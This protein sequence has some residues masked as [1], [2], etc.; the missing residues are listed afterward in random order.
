[1]RPRLFV[2]S[3][4]V[5]HERTAFAHSVADVGDIVCGGDA[6]RGELDPFEGV[7]FESVVEQPHAVAEKDRGDVQL[8]LVEQSEGDHLAEQGAASGDR[9]VLVFCCFAGLFDGRVDA[10]GHVGEAGASLSVQRGSRTMGDDEDRG[11]ERWLGAPGDLATVRHPPTHHVGAGRVERL[12]DDVGVD[13][14]LSAGEAEA[15]PPGLRVDGPAGDAEEACGFRA[16]Q[17]GL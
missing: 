11:A 9:D 5:Q 3:A 2:V 12:G 1:M 15:L 10:V 16:V 17:P 8:E 13:V 7:E 4:V 6:V 14:L